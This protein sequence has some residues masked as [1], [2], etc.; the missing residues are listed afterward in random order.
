MAKQKIRYRKVGNVVTPG[1]MLADITELETRDATDAPANIFN[2]GDTLNVHCHIIYP[3]EIADVKAEYNLNL[4]CI[5]LAPSVGSGPYA[6]T[7]TDNLAVNTTEVDVP[8]SFTASSP[9]SGP[10]VYLLLGTLD[11]G[12]AS[13][14]GAWL[15]SNLFFVIP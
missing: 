15:F 4:Y 7:V 5:Q 10:G 2:V 8:F 11:F 13:D 9:G 14:F 1:D 12:P 6:G 3:E